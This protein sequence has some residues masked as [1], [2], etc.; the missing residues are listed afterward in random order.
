MILIFS[1]QGDH[2]SYYII[3]IIIIIELNLNQLIP[4]GSKSDL[5]FFV[6]EEFPKL[7]IQFLFLFVDNIFSFKCLIKI[8]FQKNTTD[9][10]HYSTGV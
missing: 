9:S 7:F 10:I 4:S 1:Y 8:Q 6:F 3:I 2:R 5:I